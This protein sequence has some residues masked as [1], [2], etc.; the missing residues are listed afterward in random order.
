[1]NKPGILG[2]YKTKTRDSGA[3]GA[4]GFWFSLGDSVRRVWHPTKNLPHENFPWLSRF[5]KSPKQWI[6]LVQPEEWTE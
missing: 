4:N 2:L 6:L 3:E 5:E 1:M